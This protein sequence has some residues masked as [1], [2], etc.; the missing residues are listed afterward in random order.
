MKP[1]TKFDRNAFSM[2]TFKQASHKL[3]YWKSKSPAERLEAA[4]ILTCHAY[5]FSP[6]NPPKMDRTVFSMRKHLG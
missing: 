5:G 4:W 2:G 6:E 1:D 3:S